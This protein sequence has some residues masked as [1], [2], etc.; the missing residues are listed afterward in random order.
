MSEPH[1]SDRQADRQTD[2]R[3]SRSTGF[4]ETLSQETRWKA[5]EESLELASSYASS[6]I[7]CFYIKSTECILTL[8]LAGEITT[9]SYTSK[10]NSV[11]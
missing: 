3:N 9:D 5:P 6:H 10:L 1:W 7:I 11:F 2:Y 4:S 8:L